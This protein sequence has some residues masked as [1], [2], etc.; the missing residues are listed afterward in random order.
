ME[1][2]LNQK[3]IEPFHYYLKFSKLL[4]K[5]IKVRILKFLNKFNIISDTQYGFRKNVSTSDALS[6]VIETVNLNLEHLNNC[7]IVSID[8][9]KAF[10]TLDHDI[11]IKKLSIYGII[12]LK[13]LEIYLKDR[14]RYVSFMNTTSNINNIAYGVPQGSVL[15]PLLFVLYINDL[16]NISNSFKPV[17]FADDT[18]LIFSDKSITALK[19]N[20]QQNLN[21]LFDRLN[22]N[23]LSLNV[24]KSSLLLFN[25]RN[26]NNNVKLNVNINDINQTSNKFNIFRNNN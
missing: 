26:K 8:L 2:D 19:T 4:E 10:D 11:L 21:K 7:P 17:L 24:S 5:L 3:I 20:I 6:D 25:I 13:L 9:C 22:I 16:P 12:A 18:N 1:I 15:G 23:K 14:Q